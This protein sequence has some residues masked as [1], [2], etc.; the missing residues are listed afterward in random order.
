MKK[1]LW[2]ALI[3][4][5]TVLALGSTSAVAGYHGTVAQAGN[6]ILKLNGGVYPKAFPREELAPL[7]FFAA[8]SISTSDGTHLPA[9]RE[10]VLDTDKDIS[11]SVKGLP[12]CRLDQLEALPPRSVKALCGG[13]FLGQGEATV[14]VAFPEQAPFNSKGPLILLN[15]GETGGVTTLL[16]YTY[17]DVPAPTVVVT[18]AK[19]TRERKGPFGLHSVIRVP[20]IAGGYGSVVSA[21]L[22][23]RRTYTYKG[24]RRSVF[25][26]RCPDRRFYARGAF[27]FHDGATVSGTFVQQCSVVG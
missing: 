17:V 11:V 19:L 8:G 26:G 18:T 3:A 27:M 25:S 9:L 7:G 22:K 1:Q 5:G 6:L 4:T 2:L 14:E 21:K 20:P 16:A 13:A 15:G 23:V 10:V 24:R 12:S